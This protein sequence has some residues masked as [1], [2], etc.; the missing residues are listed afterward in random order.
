MREQL[1]Q[2]V[3]AGRKTA[4]SALLAQYKAYHEP[5]P[6]V[7]EQRDMVDSAGQPV[8][9]VVLTDVSVI[10]LGDADDELAH[11]EG[12]GFRD[13]ADWRAAHEAFWRTYVLPELPEEMSLDDGT[14]VVVERFKLI[15]S[16]S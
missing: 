15:A 1:V 16:Q 8:G 13:A 2:A 10:R 6:R 5:L 9:R 14:Q 12:E 4:T 7:G 3:L 11:D